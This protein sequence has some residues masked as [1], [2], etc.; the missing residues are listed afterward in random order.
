MSEVIDMLKH[1]T[2]DDTDTRV[3]KYLAPKKI[4]L[5]RGEWKG[6]E[7]LLRYKNRQIGT[8]E[9]EVTTAVSTETEKA[10]ILLDFGTEL[11]GGI[12]FS[13]FRIRDGEEASFRVSF[14]ESAGEALSRIGERALP[15]ITVCAILS[16]PQKAGRSVNMALRV[17]DLYTWSF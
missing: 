2:F 7:R 8:H 10:G 4:L 17:F 11:H 9:P 16:L 1:I 5:T 12:C 6:E 13:L 3:R 14:G 15:M